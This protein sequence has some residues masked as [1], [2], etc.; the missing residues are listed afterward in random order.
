MRST[1]ESMQN[2]IRKHFVFHSAG[3]KLAHLVIFVLVGGK[4]CSLFSHETELASCASA[5]Q[6]DRA[7]WVL[8]RNPLNHACALNP[9]PFPP[10][11]PRELCSSRTFVSTKKRSGSWSIGFGYC[12]NAATERIRRERSII[13]ISRTPSNAVA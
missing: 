1:T 9:T 7:L 12:F 6:L 5:S 8:M 11:P 10:P 2:D 4:Q 3:P 13:C